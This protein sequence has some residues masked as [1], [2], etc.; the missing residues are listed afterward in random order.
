M[1]G[2]GEFYISYSFLFDYCYSFC[3]LVRQKDDV[4]KRCEI[5]SGN[6]ILFKFYLRISINGVYMFFV[7]QDASKLFIVGILL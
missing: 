2:G 5:S 3:V 1:F 7:P 6:Q 4:F